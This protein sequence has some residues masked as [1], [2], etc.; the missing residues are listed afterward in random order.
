MG[1]N[2]QRDKEFDEKNRDSGIEED[3][4]PEEN[5]F[6]EYFDELEEEGTSGSRSPVIR[7]LALVTLICFM[8]I[9]L[10]SSWPTIEI[11]LS[12][13]FKSSMELK[14]DIDVQRLQKAVVHIDV[15]AKEKSAS[16]VAA[17]QKSGTGF[18]IDPGGVI[19]TNYHVI[20][21]ALNMVI[22][23]PDDSM[24]K[25]EHWSSKPEMDIAVITLKAVDLP[26]VPV[27]PSGAPEVGDKVRVVGNPLG[28]NNIVVEGDV[29]NYLNV[30]GKSDLV[31]SLDAPIYPGNSGSPVFDKNGEV[32]GV[33]FGTL[34]KPEENGGNLGVAIPI[35]EVIKLRE[36]NT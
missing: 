18:N 19:V 8:G 32:V 2:M 1:V 25:A 35:G 33:V 12:E 23:F 31:F 20:E 4:F 5:E 13:L 29:V 3:I 9:V 28:L 34:K 14:K 11:Q 26:M 17:K 10:A 24:Y 22:K 6:D 21:G 30:K 36:Q 27:N 15:V 16:Q 7:L